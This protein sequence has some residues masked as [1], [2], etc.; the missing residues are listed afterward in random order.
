VIQHKTAAQDPQAGDVGVPFETFFERE[1][2]SVTRALVLLT[3]NGA[4]AEE[5]AE[6]AFARAWSAWDRV[7][8]MASPAGYVYKTAL[9]LHRN[10]LR[11]L[12]AEL[13]HRERPVP[14][15]DPAA[16]VET[17]DGIRRPLM[18]L[19]L[20]QREA[21]VLVEWLG[22]SDEEAGH[23][24]RIKAVSVRTRCHRARMTLRATFGGGDE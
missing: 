16:A 19:P 23:L 22:M 5:L 4:E 8:T 1:Y 13:R 11:R 21:L 17:R 7:G 15:G 3:G 14:S 24:L 6:D 2:P 12:A 9:N 10:R 20:P 18:A